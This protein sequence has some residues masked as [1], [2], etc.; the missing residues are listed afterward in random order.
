[1]LTNENIQ[2]MSLVEADGL[3]VE[4]KDLGAAFGG[5]LENVRK[6]S[7]RLRL[8]NEI[9]VGISIQLKNEDNDEPHEQGFCLRMLF[10]NRQWH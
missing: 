3:G 2:V 1:M 4:T 10:F 5:K 8:K 6:A 7:S 9:A